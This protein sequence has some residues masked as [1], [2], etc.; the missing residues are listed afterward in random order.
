MAFGRGGNNGSYRGGNRGGGKKSNYTRVGNMFESDRE[1][2]PQSARS[3]FTTKLDGKYLDAVRDVLNDNDA[4]RFVF[5]EW[6]D[7]EHPVLSVAPVTDKGGKRGGS[8]RGSDREDRTVRGRSSRDGGSRDARS[9][10]IEEEPEQE[11]VNDESE[12]SNNWEK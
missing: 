5:T 1:F 8:S 11:D 3:Q 6:K 7:G 4:V 2:M 10:G 9:R 12:E